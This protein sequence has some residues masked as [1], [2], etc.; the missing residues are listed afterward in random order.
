MKKGRRKLNAMILVVCMIV[1]AFA[2]VS[3]PS[4]AHEM[5][6]GN[7]F[8]IQWQQGWMEDD[9][10]VVAADEIIIFNY[11]DTNNQRYCLGDDGARIEVFFY[12]RMGSVANNLYCS[13]DKGSGGN[14]I[15]ADIPDDREPNGA[16]TWTLADDASQTAV[17]EIDI[18]TT[19][20]VNQVY[21]NALEITFTHDGGT[22]TFLFDLYVSSIFD[23][24]SNPDVH[25]RLEP[26]LEM[27]GDPSFE[28]GEVFQDGRVTLTNYHQGGGTT[29]DI[30]NVWVNGTL[31]SGLSF[32][33][34]NSLAKV[35]GP[36]D[37]GD[38]VWINYRIN[39]NSG[40]AP[41]IYSGTLQIDYTRNGMRIRENARS[42]DVTVDFT[43]VLQATATVPAINQGDTNVTISVTFR[44]TGNV[45]LGQL[46]IRVSLVSVS[47]GNDEY[48]FTPLDHY[49]GTTN[50]VTEWFEVNIG[51]DDTLIVNE[52]SGAVP[53]N[54]GLDAYI[55]AGTH[56]VLFDWYAYYYNTGVIGD[57][58]S[59]QHVALIWEPENDLNGVQHTPGMY[60][61]ETTNG[62]F[63]DD[64]IDTVGGD[65][66]D[67]KPW[68][69]GTY[70]MVEVVD[71]VLSV[72]ASIDVIDAD[73]DVTYV[74]LPVNLTNDENVDLINLMVTLEVGPNSPF[75][76]PTNH[77]A[78]TL[79]MDPSSPDVIGANSWTYIYFYVDIN[80]AWFTAGALDP[81]V[82]EVDLTVEATNAD[83]LEAYAP[84]TIQVD[85][86][87][88]G[89]GPELFATMVSYTEIEPGENFTL[90]VTIYNYG[91]D[92]AREVDAYLRVDFVA[93]WSIVDQFVT[94]I[95]G[96]GG[97][98]ANPPVGDA[99]WGWATDWSAYH[100]FNRSH[101]VRPGEI[102]VDNVPQIVE[103]YDWIT[104]RETPPQ[105]IVLW[106]H[107]D[108]LEPGQE[109]HVTYNMISDVNMVE[110]MAYYETLELY[111]VDSINGDTYGP[112]GPPFE[113]YYTPPQEVL[114]RSG[115]GEKYTGE[116]EF[117]YTF[118]LYALIF[119]IIAFIIFLIGYALGGR[120][121]GGR[122]PREEPYEPYTE[123]YSY[124]PPEGP[125][126]E[127][128]GPPEEEKPI[129]EEERPL[130]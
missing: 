10:N 114:I 51:T 15:I 95:G 86:P 33:Q 87:I 59:Y 130:E 42:Y 102:G 103:L 124:E 47:D 117:D 8:E 55:P 62:L 18:A 85:A 35:P 49:E 31:P 43:P 112:H 92:T 128:L 16:G 79:T 9:P 50:K 63:P 21:Q 27:Q 38:D 37:S 24:P 111:Y 90:T 96:Y 123:D 77:A 108:R 105:G 65:I 125:T 83:T 74:M 3:L 120:G 2:V 53:I 98:G 1:T 78:T 64:P 113:T 68:Q 4:G 44:N 58:T 100:Q 32:Y 23:N 84:T 41:N 6:S 28:A 45:A 40:I 34:L 99:S 61:D 60:K 14:L 118:V 101:D 66:E 97:E 54:K 48:L 69:M 13:L 76:D 73:E 30:S 75:L 7:A 25:H 72:W 119:L 115:K 57:P 67:G 71:P 94:S 81:G 22:S 5:S 19:G 121:G 56:K 88:N 39:V 46:Y 26:L 106:M 93:G 89:F 80:S 110:G 107:L 52:V 12:N 91:Q 104:R 129:E 109:W 29:D 127:G 122:E 36:I 82:F 11:D 17:F 126:E 20:N 70:A 116:E